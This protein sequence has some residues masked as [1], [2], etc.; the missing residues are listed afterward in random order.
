MKSEADEFAEIIERLKHRQKSP[1]EIAEFEAGERRHERG[2]VDEVLRLFGVPRRLRE[3]LRQLDDTQAMR[4]AREWAT[5]PDSSWC[6][7]LSSGF[8]VGKSTAAA[9]WLS[10]ASSSVQPVPG[11]FRRWWPAAEIAA[12]DSYGED[13]KRLCDCGSLVI[14][15][16]GAE[17]ADQK[18]AFASK[19]DRL[20]DARYREYR[21][22]LITTNLDPKAFVDRYDRRIFDRL[23]EGGKWQSF[24]GKS[25]R[26]A[27]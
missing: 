15:D 26:R 20:I 25:M 11:I 13:F 9:W 18:G 21:R 22:T 7:V 4:L 12:M 3:N 19:F 8:G 1:E 27:G 5:Q 6:L 2:R 10:Q 17:Y 14:D 23:R 24:V 16:A